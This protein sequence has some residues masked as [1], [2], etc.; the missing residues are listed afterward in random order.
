MR[1]IIFNCNLPNIY[2]KRKK[3]IWGKIFSASKSV[4]NLNRCICK[5]LDKQCSC[6]ELTQ[7][8]PA[9]PSLCLFFSL[10]TLFFLS[11]IAFLFLSILREVI[12][13]FEEWMGIWT[14]VPKHEIMRKL[15][16]REWLTYRWSFLWWV[17]RCIQPISFCRQWWPCLLCPWRYLSWLSRHHPCGRGWSARHTWFSTPYSNG[18][19]WSFFWCLRER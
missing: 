10:V 11:K 18:C 13:K 1:Y 4:D 3:R 6:G 19:S 15:A 16:L 7:S 5:A 2:I 14:W 8:R 17:F 12:S 9:R